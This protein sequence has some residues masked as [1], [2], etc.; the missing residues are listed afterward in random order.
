MREGSGGVGKTYPV[1][2]RNRNRNSQSSGL[3]R[4]N[5]GRTRRRSAPPDTYNTKVEADINNR[6][7]Q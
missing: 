2:Y 4:S 6:N 5:S 3:T 1:V 7:M